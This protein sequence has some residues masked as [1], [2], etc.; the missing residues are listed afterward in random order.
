MRALIIVDV[1]NDFLPGGALAVPHGDEIIPVINRLQEECDVVIASKDWHPRN[2]C[3]FNQW[4]LHCIQESWGAEFP[5]GLHTEKIEKV[6]LKG[7]LPDQESY[8]AFSKMEPYLKKR[9]VT[10][11]W[12]V[13][14]A[15]EICVKETAEEAQRK[16]WKA[17]IILEGCRALR[18]VK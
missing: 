7:E 18:I 9:G 3:S 1:Q 8:S 14:L 13:G 12:I 4:P 15:L 16:G 6:F 2:H 17:E 11:L 10:E 5:K